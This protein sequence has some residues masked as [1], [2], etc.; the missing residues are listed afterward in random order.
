VI[1]AASRSKIHLVIGK[2]FLE[3]RKKSGMTQ[4]EVA[5]KM[6]TTVQYISDFENGKNNFC[7]DY[8]IDFAAII[9][10]PL[11]KVHEHK[12]FEKATK[13]LEK[14]RKGNHV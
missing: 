9:G 12:M 5:R 6:G 3:H 4:L 7:Y 2:L 10:L 11:C 8:L 14:A 1:S 13:L